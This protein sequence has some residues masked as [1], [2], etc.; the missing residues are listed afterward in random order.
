MTGRAHDF[1]NPIEDFKILG[2]GDAAHG[3]IHNRYPI[4]K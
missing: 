1:H 2:W 3:L 4:L